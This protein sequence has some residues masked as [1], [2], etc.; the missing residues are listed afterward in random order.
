MKWIPPLK[1]IVM[2]GICG[3]LL[4]V[5]WV[6]VIPVF[7]QAECG[8]VDT[9]NFPVDQNQ[10]MLAQEFGAPSPRHQGRF[11]TGEDWYGGR[12]VSFG[13]PVRAIANGRVTY[14]YPLGWGRDG[15][16]IVIEHITADD[17]R[18]YSQYG[19]IME[20]ATITFPPRLGCIQAGEIIGAV[21]DVR[22]APH[23]HFEIRTNNPDTPGA[24]YSWERTKKNW[25]APTQ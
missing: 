21:G 15:G 2:L 20:T 9:I 24:G 5:R 1:F 17:T 10:F 25:F 4:C 23:L 22:P 12:D 19:H 14:S 6:S 3:F 8:F 16:V 18:F 13:Q 11:H 7:A